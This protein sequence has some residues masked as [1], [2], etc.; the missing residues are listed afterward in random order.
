VGDLVA[1]S[2]FTERRR[3]RESRRLHAVCRDVLAASIVAER[4]AI[5][6]APLEERAVRVRRLRKFE[7]AQAY[8]DT[9]G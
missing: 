7:D 5:A 6:T 8:A 9:T 4:L 1:F 2:S 3:S